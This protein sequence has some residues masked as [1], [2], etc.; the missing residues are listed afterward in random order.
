[1]VSP[2][3][4]SSYLLSH[5]GQW[6][7][8]SNNLMNRLTSLLQHLTASSA[9]TINGFNNRNHD[10]SKPT[11][12][13]YDALKMRHPCKKCG[14]YCHWIRD[15]ELDGSLP[16][17]V[18][19]IS[20]KNSLLQRQLCKLGFC[21]RPEEEGDFFQYGSCCRFNCIDIDET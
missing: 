20:E 21:K 14:K 13:E 5:I 7:Q 1:M 16:P 19:S 4:T 11:K 8:L 9:G 10:R 12:A 18:K 6:P 17:H 2:Q 3:M 15:H